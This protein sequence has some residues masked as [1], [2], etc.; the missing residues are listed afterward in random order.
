[1]ENTNT[2][3]DIDTTAEAIGSQATES[4]VQSDTEASST[5]QQSAPKLSRKVKLKIDG[6]EVEEEL[7]FEIDETNEEAVKFLKRHLQMSKASAK[8]MTEAAQL[9]KQ[10]ESFIHSLQNDPMAVLSN[11]QIMGNEKFRA[12]AEEFLAQQL[13]NEL[14]SPEEREKQELQNRLRRYE[15]AERRAHEKQEQE[16][17]E[18]LQQHYAEQFQTTI[19]NALTHSGLPQNPFTVKRM[20]QLMQK[21][22]ENGIDLSPEDLSALVRDDY[23]RELAALIGSSNGE[24][25]LSLFGEDAANKIRKH[26]LEKL[27]ATQFQPKPSTQQPVP[28]NSDT[29]PK[30]A[31]SRDEWREY[32]DKKISD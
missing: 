23:K 6:S 32:L 20:A 29:P 2:N 25:I 13:Q 28:S 4:E 12:I 27:K 5:E 17:I 3:T 9:R 18:T 1:M 19:V 11:P 24:T 16:Q 26:D 22:I 31:L 14:L 21:S 15:E 10:A 7:P 30:R 8:R